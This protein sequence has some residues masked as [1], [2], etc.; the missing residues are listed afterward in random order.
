MGTAT[1]SSSSFSV[2]FRDVSLDLL[3]CLLPRYHL[4]TTEADPGSADWVDVYVRLSF[5]WSWSSSSTHTDRSNLF[6]TDDDRSTFI[7]EISTVGNQKHEPCPLLPCWAPRLEEP[8][9]CLPERGLEDLSWGALF[10]VVVVAVEKVSKHSL[11]SRDVHSLQAVHALCAGLRQRQARP[12][13]WTPL[14]VLDTPG[15]T[16]DR[17]LHYNHSIEME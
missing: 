2:C 12:P 11:I 10:G 17:E 4:I 5:T 9:V 7:P 8:V 14:V 1:V 3:Q 16:E 13:V 6:D 15:R